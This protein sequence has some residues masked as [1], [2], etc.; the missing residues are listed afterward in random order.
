[1]EEPTLNMDINKIKPE[2]LLQMFRLVSLQRLQNKLHIAEE[3]NPALFHGMVKLIWSSVERKQRASFRKF[4]DH[5][6]YGT[7]T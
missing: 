5:G 4:L 7:G 1:M 6:N 2:E 3:E